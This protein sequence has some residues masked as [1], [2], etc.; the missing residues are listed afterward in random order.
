MNCVIFFKNSIYDFQ[1][2]FLYACEFPAAKRIDKNYANM[3][4]GEIMDE[5][6]LMNDANVE[7]LQ[8][9]YIM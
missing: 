8:N 2:I 9:K 6:L 1:I 5:L 3:S 7:L 4:I